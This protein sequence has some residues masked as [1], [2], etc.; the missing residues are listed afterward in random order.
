MGPAPVRGALAGA[1]LS[2]PPARV[3]ELLQRSPSEATVDEAVRRHGPHANTARKH[4]EGLVA[5]LGGRT[6]L[7]LVRGALDVLGGHPQDVVLEPF[8][9]PGACLLRL[10]ADGQRVAS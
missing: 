6:N 3:L 9:E 1:S 4:L 2:G 10:S 5:E 7:G 8:A